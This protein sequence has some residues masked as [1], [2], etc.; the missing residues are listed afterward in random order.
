MA[1]RSFLVAA[2]LASTATAA[3]AGGAQTLVLATYAYPKYDRAAALRPLAGHLSARLETPVDVVVHESPQALADAILAG[4]VDVAVTNTFAFLAVRKDAAVRAVAAF[5]VPGTTPAG[6]RGVL[7]ARRERAPDT[8]T[9]VRD[10][11]RLRYAQV[12]PGSTSGGLVQDLHLA[13]LGLSPSRFAERSDAGT[14]DAAL[15]R[16]VD[17]TADVAALAEEPWRALRE[18]SPQVALGLV[19]LW[20]SPPIPA[21]P[22][23]CRRST[24]L[25]CEDVERLLL[26]LDDESPAALTSL[27]AAWSEFA[28]A[29]RLI[30]VDLHTFDALGAGSSAARDA[31][32]RARHSYQRTQK[33]DPRSRMLSQSMRPLST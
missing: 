23:V 21:G 13:T 15:A 9:L 29:R 4:R 17:G 18:R 30:G 26:A 14:H 12:I 32:L 22:V 33:R 8:A 28:G 31:L 16:L 3:F 24:R 6:Y 11:A 2:L 5:D 25:A 7:V 20:R 27:V 19:Q 1:L 10:A